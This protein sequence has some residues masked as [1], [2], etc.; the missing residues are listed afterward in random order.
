MTKSFRETVDVGELSFCR[1]VFSDGT[2]YLKF[3]DDC[4]TVGFT[5]DEETVIERVSSSFKFKTKTEQI[6]VEVDSVLSPLILKVLV[7][8]NV[9]INFVKPIK[10][11]FR[12]IVNSMGDVEGAI[13]KLKLNVKKPE[14]FSPMKNPFLPENRFDEERIDKLTDGHLNA[15][16][17]DIVDSVERI[18][19]KA[20]RYYWCGK[21]T[22][23]ELSDIVAYIV[24]DVI[25]RRQK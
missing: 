19:D 10:H 2:Q 20:N 8:N 16:K 6:S 4:N 14:K 15:F 17:N 18:L 13:K 21:I 3:C 1:E 9:V 25:E 23:T 12:K 11:D 22:E 24:R 7:N 5:I